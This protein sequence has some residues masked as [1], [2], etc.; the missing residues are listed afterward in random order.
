[1][2]KKLWFQFLKALAMLAG[3]V[4]A[5]DILL[6]TA[7]VLFRNLGWR[8]LG[9]ASDVIE[10]S[11]SLST[12][13]V[14]PWLVA[15]KGHVK[16]DLLVERMASGQRNVL[17]RFTMWLAAGVTAVLVYASTLLALDTY[18]SGA[19]VMKSLVFPEWWVMAAVP[20]LFL[21]IAIE[22]LRSALAG[23]D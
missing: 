19:L 14:A 11:L 12:L 5:V 16:L 10:Y 2:F 1:M 3:V 8:G 20:P 7:E 6:I 23:A 4:L 17:Y 22:C 9:W 18:T 13:L 15:Q 21:L